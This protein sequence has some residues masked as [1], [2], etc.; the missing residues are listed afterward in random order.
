MVLTREDEYRVHTPGRAWRRKGWSV[1]ERRLVEVVDTVPFKSP[2][3][4]LSLLPTDLPDAFSTADLA[5]SLRRPRRVAQQMAYCLKKAG[6][7]DPV[8]KV[9][10]A[11]R[12]RVD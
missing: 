6:V 11:V 1:L 8:D 7:V 9:G 2:G 3:D 5:T 4:L 10:N 12:Y